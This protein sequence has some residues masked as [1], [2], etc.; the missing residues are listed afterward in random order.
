MTHP[1]P[2]TAA[3]VAVNRFGL[4]VR[5]DEALPG[6]ARGW[7]LA[8]FDSYV[9]QPPA[10][11]EQPSSAALLVAYGDLV[12]AQRQ[13]DATS[14]VAT[15][16]KLAA[17]VRDRYRAAVGARIA[18]ALV[19]PAPFAERLVHFWANHFAVS[20]EKPSIGSIAGAFEA[21]AIR[22][23]VFGSFETLLLAVERHP[24]MLIYLDQVRSIGPARWSNGRRREPPSRRRSSR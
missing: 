16:Q 1:D 22:P 8:Q 3:A 11:A 13:A 17:E 19:T 18:T 24:A 4:G 21:E 14:E 12:R 23:N 20:I 5:A 2:T 7:L 10:W 6:N 15:R 9:A